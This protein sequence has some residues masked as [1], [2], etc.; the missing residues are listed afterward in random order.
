MAIM[1]GIN[2][3]EVKRIR[4]LPSEVDTGVGKHHRAV[5]VVTGWLQD[6]E[7][8][9]SR[10][11]P[12]ILRYGEPKD[13]FNQLVKRYGG[14]VPARAMLDE[15]ER[16]GTVE[17]LLRMARFP[18]D[19]RAMYRIRAES[20]LLDIFATSASDLLTTL[21][22]NLH[23]TDQRR[24]QM[25]VAYDD[26]TTA[27]KD[28]FRKLSAE[29]GMSL[30][31]ALDRSLAEVDRGSNPD[32]YRRGPPPCRSGYLLDRRYFPSCGAVDRAREKG[33]T[34]T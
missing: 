34:I 2:R 12:L 29:K 9:N 4:E 30:L 17:H 1:T 10:G 33:R 27:G 28:E 24:L 21:E 26:V 20:A 3:K 14:D 11:K 25:S 22:H 18:C 19:T 7:F 13:S 15:L 23:R 8:Q 16:V 31:K 6:Q 5:R 32:G